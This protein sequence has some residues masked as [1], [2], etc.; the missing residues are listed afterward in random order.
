[1]IIDENFQISHMLGLPVHGLIGFNLFKDYIVKIDYSG[2]KLTLYRPEHYKYRDRRKDIIM[3]CIL[4]E[5][6]LLYAPLL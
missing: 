2:E 3:P 5:T 1:M 6:N 4:K